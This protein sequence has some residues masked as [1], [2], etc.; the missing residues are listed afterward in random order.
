VLQFVNSAYC[1][2]AQRT[3]S[4]ESAIMCLGLNTLR[5]LALTA[6]MFHGFGASGGRAFERAERHAVLTARIARRITPDPAA[7]EVAFAAGLLH[8]A[9][10]LVLM[11]RSPGAYQRAADEAQRTGVP[12][13]AHE[14][15]VLGATH[16][17]VGAYLLGLWDLPHHIVEAAAFHHA[18]DRVAGRSGGPVDIT[19]IVAIA[20]A[21]AH[22]VAK[23][24]AE[25]TAALLEALESLGD[26]SRHR[27]LALAEASGVE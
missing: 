18:I 2:F 5:H 20:D 27:E 26:L 1:G 9:G 13:H 15:A 6:E 17:E 4:L 10:K 24:E 21:L 16:A 7:K 19:A 25:G 8:D 14:R 22:E 11:S 23:D 3:S 12:R